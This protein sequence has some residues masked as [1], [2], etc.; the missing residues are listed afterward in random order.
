MNAG[1]PTIPIGRVRGIPVGVH[2]SVLVALFVV[3]QVPATAVLPQPAPGH[4]PATCWTVGVLTAIGSML[5]LLGHEPAHSVVARWH[6]VGVRRVDLWLLGGM[7][8]LSA[9][10]PSPRA[11]FLIAVAGPG[12][13]VAF[14]SA[15]AGTGLLLA[16]SRADRRTTS[17]R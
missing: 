9:T 4:S 5:S 16:G 15:A 10:P 6:G 12:A 14:G 7:S 1:P 17:G 13:S 11:E 8:Q 2:W 3:G